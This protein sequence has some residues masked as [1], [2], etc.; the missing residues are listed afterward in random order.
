VQFQQNAKGHVKGS[1]L[2]VGGGVTPPVEL[3]ERF[4]VYRPV[5]LALAAGDRVRITAGGQTKDGK[6]RLANGDLLTIDGFTR[7]G[8][9][10]VDH[11]WI[12]DRDFGHLTHGYVATSHASQGDTVNKVFVAIASQR[13]MSGQPMWP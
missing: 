12:I 2:I 10:V 13:P 6:H 7:N 8:D 5:Q 1:R 4:E 9:L 3:A 11:G